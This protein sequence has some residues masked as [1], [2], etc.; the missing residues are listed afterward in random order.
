MQKSSQKIAVL[1][2]GGLDSAIL[3][4]KLLGEG[5]VIFPIYV[6]SGNIWESAETK[7]LRRYLK[8]IRHPKLK[9]LVSLMFPIGDI[10]KNFWSVSGRHVPGENSK[11][12]AV[13][14]PGK[15]IL[16]IAKAAI[17]CAQNKIRKIA[18]APL[19]TNPFCDAKR[20]F[21][22]QY[23]RALSSGLGFPLK[24]LTPFLALTKKEVMRLGKEF[25]LALTFSCLNPKGNLHCGRCNKCAERK[26]AFQ[27]AEI[28]D[29]TRYA[30]SQS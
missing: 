15:N 23:E 18:L 21:F 28:K 24:I 29:P 22:D 13:Y 16:L 19:K 9:P 14:L 6:S 12:E 5:N 3:L 26:K 30:I 20:S 10:Y 7:W 1:T 27:S 11:D 25:P 2:S 8:A 17:H 4:K